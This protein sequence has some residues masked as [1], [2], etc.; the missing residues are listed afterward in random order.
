MGPGAGLAFDSGPPP[1]LLASKEHFM[2]TPRP[3]GRQ[4]DRIKTVVF[5]AISSAIVVG[6]IYALALPGDRAYVAAVAIIALQVWALL[7][8]GAVVLLAHRRRHVMTTAEE[9]RNKLAEADVRENDLRREL[10]AALTDP[11]TGLPTRTVAEN[12]ITAAA[13]QGQ[14]LAIAL[15]D[16][17]GLNKVNDDGGH[18][19]GDLYLIAIADRLTTAARAVTADALIARTGGDEF[20]ILAPDTDSGEL[21]DAIRAAFAEPIRDERWTS[22][23]ASVGVAASNGTNPRHALAQADAAMYTA[24]RAGNQ[25]LVYD[26]DRDGAPRADG[27]R[28]QVR[29]RD[30]KPGRDILVS[31]DGSAALVRLVCSTADAETIV[32]ALWIAHERWAAT[33]EPAPVE[34]RE[35]APVDQMIDVAPTG[36]GIDRIRALAQGE[37]AKYADLAGRIS[38]TLD[39]QGSQP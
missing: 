32:N 10:T 35:P 38:A 6:P 8:T 21:A 31:A 29:R 13:A 18:P 14:P 9:L 30:L 19:A 22:P 7:C 20:V 11:L 25:T 15:A 37:V 39:P 34:S 33:I 5:D 26:P 4:S 27:T 23:R 1:V 16:A 36:G 3:P 12:A 17:D 28:V 2:F 24:K